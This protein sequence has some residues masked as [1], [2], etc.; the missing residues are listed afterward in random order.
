[1][2]TV[3]SVWASLNPPVVFK[4]ELKTNP[5]LQKKVNIDFIQISIAV[6]NICLWVDFDSAAK[7]TIIESV[8]DYQGYKQK[9]QRWPLYLW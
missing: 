2:L 1:M 4:R 5:K 7:I 9:Q 3:H 6:H 8:S